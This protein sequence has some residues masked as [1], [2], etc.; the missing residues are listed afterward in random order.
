[1]HR[2]SWDAGNVLYVYK[3][4]C[5]HEWFVCILPCS[6]HVHFSLSNL[7]PNKSAY[8]SKFFKFYIFLSSWWF[9]GVIAKSWNWDKMVQKNQ[10]DANKVTTQPV[11]SHQPLRTQ[12][13]KS[14]QRRLSDCWKGQPMKLDTKVTWEEENSDANHER[15]HSHLYLKRRVTSSKQS[16]HFSP[17]LQ[18]NN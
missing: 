4:G 18:E 6:C 5:I 11:D 2:V 1:M 14:K 15:S 16:R 13:A 9:R 12:F 10:Q 8:K 17:S 3:Y 7:I